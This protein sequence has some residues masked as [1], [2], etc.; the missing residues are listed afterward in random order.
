MPLPDQPLHWTENLRK[1]QRPFALVFLSIMMGY[2]VVTGNQTAKEVII[3]L[4]K[5][6]IVWLFAERAVLKKPGQ[7]S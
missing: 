7:D 6:V 5:M 2:L 3:D 4:G 1:A